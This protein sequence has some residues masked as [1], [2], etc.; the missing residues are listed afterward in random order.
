MIRNNFKKVNRQPNYNLIN[1]HPYNTYFELNFG[2]MLSEEYR[3]R[4]NSKIEVYMNVC[5]SAW[6]ERL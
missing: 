2:D 3:N 5:E 6:K 1:I 4:V